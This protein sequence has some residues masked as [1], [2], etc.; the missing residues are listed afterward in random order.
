MRVVKS[1]AGFAF[2]LAAA[3]G[4]LELTGALLDAGGTEARPRP[5]FADGPLSVAV[6]EATQRSFA[7]EVRAVGSTRSLHHLDVHPQAEGTVTR[8]A[9]TSGDTVAAGDVLVTLDTGAEEA[10]LKAAQATLAEAEAAAARQRQLANSP[11]SSAAL[12]QAAEAALLRAQADVQTAEHDLEQRT[13]TA[14]F[15]GIVGLTELEVG[16]RVDTATTVTTLDDLTAVEV[17][18]SVPERYLARVTQGLDVR[19]TSPAY[20][21]RVFTGKIERL[22]TRIDTAT[23][24][25]ALRAVVPNPDLA[26]R[27]GMFMDVTLTFEERSG[28][29]IP[30]AALVADGAETFVWTVADGKAARRT[31]VSG[32]SRDGFVEIVDGLSTADAVIVSGLDQIADGHKVTA[33]P[34]EPAARAGIASPERAS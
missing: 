3:V 8:I 25:L 29:A 26:L 10:E 31:V 5:P 11:A 4:G 15:S 7:D 21:D 23:R 34:A 17:A 33:T 1:I 30:E 28:P 20:P 32:A 19:L 18:F 2:L 22:D 16:S 9:F 27:G 14:P 12:V 13:L 24:S 6:V